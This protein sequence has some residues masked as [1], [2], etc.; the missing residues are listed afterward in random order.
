MLLMKDHHMSETL[1]P[2]APDE[3][4]DVRMLPRALR[5]DYYFFDAHGGG[6]HYP[7]PARARRHPDPARRTSRCPASPGNARTR[8]APRPDADHH[9][10][11]ARQRVDPH[12]GGEPRLARVPADAA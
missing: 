7:P 1:M 9:R 3:V 8:P 5:C 11:D 10:P 2:D 6:C 12:A 4:L